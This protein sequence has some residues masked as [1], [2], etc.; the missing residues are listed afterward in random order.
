VAARKTTSF[1]LPSFNHFARRRKYG[2]KEA[3]GREG[4]TRGELAYQVRTPEKD[5]V[6]NGHR[7]IWVSQGKSYFWGNWSEE[8]NL[9]SPLERKQEEKGEVSARHQGIKGK[10]DLPKIS[11]VLCGPGVSFRVP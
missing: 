9:K 7:P 8:T 6:P 10:G 2:K 3:K 4:A 5:N 1:A 11:L